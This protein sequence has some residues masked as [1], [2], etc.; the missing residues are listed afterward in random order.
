MRLILRTGHRATAAADECRH[1][2]RATVMFE[3]RAK[4]G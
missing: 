1:G 2:H 4:S 3:F